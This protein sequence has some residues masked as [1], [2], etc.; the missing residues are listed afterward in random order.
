[1]KIKKALSKLRVI[2]K[3]GI[4]LLI[5]GI[6]IIVFINPNIT[7]DMLEKLYYIS[8]VGSLFFIVYQIYLSRQDM[9]FR[10]QYQIREKSVEMAN[11]FSQIIKIIPSTIE[12]TLNEELKKKLK[13]CDDNYSK[14]KEFDIEE[15]QEVFQI[16]EKELEEKLN[17]VNLGFDE[18]LNIFFHQNGIEEYKNKVSFFKKNSFLKYTKEE[19]EN[20]QE[21]DKK[22][23]MVFYNMEYKNFIKEVA[24]E[25]MRGRVALL[26]RLEWFSMNFITKIAN[27]ETVYQSLH[28]VYLKIVKLFYFHIAIT[29]NNGAK[30]KYYCYTIELYNIWARRY[31]QHIELET[32]HK[33]EIKSKLRCNIVVEA[34]DLTK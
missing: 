28:Q 32:E 8:F 17:I 3:I 4:V 29:N 12:L 6:G 23:A 13:A 31:Q 34:S 7:C 25:C 22:V 20:C 19:I 1:M 27:E 15:M 2:L 21:E 18:I 9:N 24:A 33:K 26:N 16:E 30:D 14:L 10:F 5:L 11:E